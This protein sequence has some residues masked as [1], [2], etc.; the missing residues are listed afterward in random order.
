MFVRRC[1]SKC[2]NEAITFPKLNVVLAIHLFGSTSRRLLVNA[3]AAQI[4]C[5]L[6]S[7]TNTS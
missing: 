6:L 5:R 2:S 3:V 4:T 7:T 1:T